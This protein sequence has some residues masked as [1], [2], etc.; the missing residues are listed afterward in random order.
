MRALKALVAGLG[1]LIVGGMALLAYGLYM[2]ASDPD[3]SIFRDDAGE[4]APAKRFGRVELSLPKGCSIVEV[5][6]DG[7]RIYLHV[8]P[9]IGSCERIIV[10]DA[11]DGTVLGTIVVGP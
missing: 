5:R 6:A 8:G 11:A 7:P 4:S 9:P 3:F 2:K 10:I 1:V